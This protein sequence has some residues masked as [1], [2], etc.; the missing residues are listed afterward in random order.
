MSPIF[1]ERS[2]AARARRLS[3]PLAILAVAGLAACGAPGGGYFSANTTSERYDLANPIGLA[4]NAQQLETPVADQLSAREQSR[5]AEFARRYIARGEGDLTIGYPNGVNAARA[6]KAIVA[7]VER[8]GV[9]SARIVRGPY[10]TEADGDRGVVLWFDAVEAVAPRC[11]EE[12]N[13]TLQTFNN[14]QP[15]DFGCAYQANLAAMIA[16]PRDLRRPRPMSPA[17]STRR[18]RTL[19]DY[20]KG[21]AT[22]SD[23][24]GEHVS[25]TDD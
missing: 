22:V 10:S 24:N 2:V 19:T 20:Q 11:F 14:Q 1:T 13:D 4:V 5:I 25:T 9:P 16:D 3:A 18:L 7:V 12:G 15:K 21:E 17:S 6:V 8:A 23:S